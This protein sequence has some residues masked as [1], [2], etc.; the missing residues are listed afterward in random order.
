[1]PQKCV[2]RAAQALA[3]R[4]YVF[5]ETLLGKCCSREAPW[6]AAA[7]RRFS[8]CELARSFGPKSAVCKTASKLAWQ[9]RQQ[10]TALQGASGAGSATQ[11]RKSFCDVWAQGPTRKFL[12]S[13]W[14]SGIGMDQV[15][16]FADSCV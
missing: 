16:G 8:C 14:Q 2:R 1:M 6:S 13:N 9:E 15:S 4:N 11:N 7:C 3:V 12:T 10:A 5:S